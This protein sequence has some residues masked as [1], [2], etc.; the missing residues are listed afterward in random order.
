VEIPTPPAPAEISAPAPEPIYADAAPVFRP[1]LVHR[2]RHIPT[3]RE[4]QWQ[5]AALL[6]SVATLAAMLGFAL[7]G[8]MRPSSPLP[9]SLIQSGVQQQVPFG[10]AKAVPAATRAPAPA[11]PAAPVKAEGLKPSPAK[12]AQAR[13]ARRVAG[14][15]DSIAEDE[16]IVRHHQPALP[17]KPAQTTAAVRRITDEN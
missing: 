15:R 12:P 17:A 9:A 7:A 1:K 6:A 3:A 4:R 14:G 2:R 5:R 8:N 16:V 10:P 13:R 11:R